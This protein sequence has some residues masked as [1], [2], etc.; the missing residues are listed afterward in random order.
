MEEIAEGTRFVIDG[1]VFTYIG[2]G[3]DAD[4]QPVAHLRGGD[5]D[6]L[7]EYP[8]DALQN[9]ERACVM[10]GRPTGRE[11]RPEAAPSAPK[12]TPAPWSSRPGTGTGSQLRC[13]RRAGRP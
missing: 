2:D 8:K 12:E 3:E 4:G 7:E 10:G 1:Q 11:S 13:G 9:L 6:S 5:S